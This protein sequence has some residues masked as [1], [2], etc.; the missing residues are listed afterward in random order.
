MKNIVQNLRNPM[1]WVYLFSFTKIF[2]AA[3][4]IEMPD[5]Q[6]NTWEQV[7][8][9]ACGVGVALGIFHFNPFQRGGKKE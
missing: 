6:W 4:G 8:N 7:L 5:D 3:I 1:A 2:L 9:A